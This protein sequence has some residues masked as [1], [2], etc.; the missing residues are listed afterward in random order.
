V[1]LSE[2]TN[3]RWRSGNQE[4]AEAVHQSTARSVDD[5][6]TSIDQ[7]ASA[8]ARSTARSWA[9][10]PFLRQAAKRAPAPKH[11]SCSAPLRSLTGVAGYF[12]VDS[13]GH[14]VASDD[15]GL[16]SRAPA[17]EFGETLV[18]EVSRAPDHSMVILP[19]G[20]PPGP[21][22]QAELR[23]DIL[24]AAGIPDQKGIV[25]GALV[26]RLDPRLELSRI[27]QRDGLANRARRMPS[28]APGH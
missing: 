23:R 17:R 3:T 15:A 5:C 2:S 25:T 21:P 26:L 11:G 24:V 8:W 20:A 4:R 1:V 27:L 12:V 6:L 22:D 19:G 7:E 16:L 9:A 14:V 13:K 10:V 18:S 28:L